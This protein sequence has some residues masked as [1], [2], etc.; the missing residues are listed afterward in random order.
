MERYE[1]VIF[2]T[3]I[4]FIISVFFFLFS[5]FINF[6]YYLWGAGDVLVSMNFL[7]RYLIGNLYF[8]SCCL[9]KQKA[10]WLSTLTVPN[11]PSPNFTLTSPPH[12]WTHNQE[13]PLKINT[14]KKPLAVSYFLICAHTHTY[15]HDTY[16]HI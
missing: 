8:F 11:P 12:L 4:L 7:S 15:I 16:V 1:A 5:V 2:C 3:Q 6:M 10:V 13:L 14:H 9:Q